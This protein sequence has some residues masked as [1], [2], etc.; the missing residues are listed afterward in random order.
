M[1]DATKTPSVNQRIRADKHAPVRPLNLLFS[2]AI[3]YIT[4]QFIHNEDLYE[5]MS[6]IILLALLKF[7]Q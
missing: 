1:N 3:F 7:Y 6:L 2:V 4:N 5:Q